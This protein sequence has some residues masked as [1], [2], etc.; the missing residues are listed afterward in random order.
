MAVLNAA[1]R[2]QTRRNEVMMSKETREEQISEGNVSV[3]GNPCD[4]NA[5]NIS[6]D[7]DFGDL[8]VSDLL[9]TVRVCSNVDES[10]LTSIGVCKSPNDAASTSMSFGRALLYA[11]NATISDEVLEPVKVETYSELYSRLKSHKLAREALAKQKRLKEEYAREVEHRKK[12]SEAKDYLRKD[13]LRYYSAPKIEYIN[14][15]DGENESESGKNKDEILDCVLKSFATGKLSLVNKNVT[16]DV[17][18]RAVSTTMGLQLGNLVEV[19]LA[20]NGLKELP[21]NMHQTLTRL[22]RLDVSQNAL[23]WI[24]DC[25]GNMESLEELNLQYN[26]L[27][28]LNPRIT[29]LKKLTILNVGGNSLR[30]LP[31]AIGRLRKLVILGAENNA[32]NMLPPS[33]YELKNLRTL[34]VNQNQLQALAVIPMLEHKPRLKNQEE[35]EEEEAWD[36][37]VDSETGDVVYVNKITGEATRR[38]PEVYCR[39]ASLIMAIHLSC[40]KWTMTMCMRQIRRVMTKRTK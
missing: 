4:I 23:T 37:I 5:N 10:E 7:A 40:A 38:R 9:G 22:L 25:I 12:V 29:E 19:A 36:Q 13:K 32:I 33:I 34:N 11:H 28:A 14:N 39:T 1:F 20:N 17:I 27:A 30:A 18:T 2:R 35:E 26:R 6:K 31:P 16:P 21:N 24:D 8:S 15:A 3:E